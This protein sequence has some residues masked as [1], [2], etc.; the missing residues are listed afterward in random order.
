MEIKKERKSWE[1]I[2]CG[3]LLGTIEDESSVDIKHKDLFVTCEGGRVTIKCRHCA[4]SQKIDLFTNVQ[5]IPRY[6]AFFH[7]FG[8]GTARIFSGKKTIG[9]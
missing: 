1:C 4:K 5:W 7:K 9:L 6:K 3:Q 2:G 8:E